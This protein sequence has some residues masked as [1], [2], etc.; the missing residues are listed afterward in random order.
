MAKSKAAI[1]LPPI[2]LIRDIGA[3]DRVI[4]DWTALT[5]YAPFPCRCPLLSLS[6]PLLTQLIDQEILTVPQFTLECGATLKQ[7]P[8][9][10]KT[11]G[12]LNETR[13]NVMI[14]CHAFTGSADVEDW[15]GPMMGR[16]KAFDPRR[17][18]VLCANTLGSPYGTAS[19]ITVNPDTGHHYGPAFP[20]T[21]IR[22]DV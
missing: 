7:V 14:I 5:F 2:P 20:P 6:M 8:V 3:R 11:W 10:Y 22:D 16:G 13:D 21:T 17:F 15:W 18:F 4:Q 12:R 19:P 9:A 1:R